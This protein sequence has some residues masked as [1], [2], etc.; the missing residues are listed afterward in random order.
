METGPSRSD[1]SNDPT[2]I[3][4]QF[5]KVKDE[6]L[7]LAKKRK[8][9][10]LANVKI[11]TVLSLKAIVLTG[12]FATRLRPLT[13]TKPKSL[14]PILGKP[15]LDWIL[16]GLAKAGLKEVILSVRYL[17]D[18]IKRRYG[19]GSSVGCFIKY[20]EEVKPLGDAGPI[21]LIDKDI[22][23]DSTFIVVYGDIFSNINYRDLIYYH[24]KNGGLATLVLTR[25]DNPYRYGVAVVDDEN[26]IVDFI[27]KP[28]KNQAKSNLVNAGIYVFEP[29]VLKYFPDKA[30]SK[31]AKDVIPKLVK[32]GVIYGYVH[33]GLW[34]DIGVPADYLRANFEALLHYYPEGYVSKTADINGAEVVKPVYVGDDV[35]V[36]SESV[37]GP[38]TIINHGCK[39]G[40]FTKISKSIL[41]GNVIVEGSSLIMKSIIGERCYI[42]KWVRVSE[43]SVIGDEVV[44]RDCVYIARNVVILPYK[45]LT[46]SVMKEGDVVL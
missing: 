45:E 37:I 14:L 25:V 36:D 41:L 46:S 38:F 27:E 30:P 15:L 13:L 22:G 33:N 9:L 42:G 31:L 40:R 24:K 17:A 39:I 28:S 7:D 8:S 6:F 34:S 29:E 5:I 26:K 16:E 11:L 3:K 20:A 44:V 43:D 23:L 4:P 12:G 21:P 10:F 19:D 35:I 32:D 18:M 1:T 2:N